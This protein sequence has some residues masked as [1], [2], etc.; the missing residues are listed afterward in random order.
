MSKELWFAEMERLTAEYEDEGM[1]PDTAY[2]RACENAH[3]AM[4]D[5]MADHA[6]YLRKAARENAAFSKQPTGDN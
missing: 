3:D 6:D 5:R 2:A 1:D 4:V